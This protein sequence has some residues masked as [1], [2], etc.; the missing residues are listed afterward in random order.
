[1][2]TNNTRRHFRDDV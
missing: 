1:V 2:P